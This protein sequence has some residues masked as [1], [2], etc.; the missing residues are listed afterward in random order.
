M[1]RTAAPL[2]ARLMDQERLAGVGNLLADEILWRADLAPG[3][4]TPLD[5][6]EFRR[7]HKELRATLRQLSRR[8][9]SHMGE[10]MEERHDGGRCPRDGTELRRE[11]VGRPHHL[12]VPGAPA[13]S[14]VHSP[15][16]QLW[17]SAQ[18][19]SGG[20]PLAIRSTPKTRKSTAMTAALW[21]VSQVLAESRLAFAFA[22]PTSA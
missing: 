2:K 8:G 6:E 15:R 4:R 13:L 11:V 3:R 14:E 21:A 22:P 12:L 18:C 9:G 1:A 7:L 5:D 17:V 16:R 20:S 10:L 19:V